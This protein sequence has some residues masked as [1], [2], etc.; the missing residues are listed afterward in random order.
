MQKIDHCVHKCTL[1]HGLAE[2]FPDTNT[3]FLG[4]NNDIVLVKEA[5]ANNGWR[6]SHLLWRDESG[7]MLLSGVV[8][9]KLFDIIGK[10]ILEMTFLEAVKCYPLDRKN[11]KVCSFHCKQFMMSQLEI[12]NS[13]LIITLEEFPTR[14]LLNVLFHKFS[15]VVGNCASC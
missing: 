9:Q 3:V 11:L 13:K 5:P 10:N 14:T 2:K 15:S 1:C 4:N 8:L 6:K 12:L 7:K